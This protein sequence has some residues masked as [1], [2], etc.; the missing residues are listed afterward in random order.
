MND[1]LNPTEDYKGALE[2]FQNNLW[3]VI[4]DLNHAQE[5]YNNYSNRGEQ[6]GRLKQLESLVSQA[7]ELAAELIG[8]LS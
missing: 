3:V 1:E 6:S 5:K 8:E 2:D 7:Q 4:D